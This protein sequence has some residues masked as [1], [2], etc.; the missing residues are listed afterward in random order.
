[1]ALGEYDWREK[2]NYP[3]ERDSTLCASAGILDEDLGRRELVFLRMGAVVGVGRMVLSER[4]YAD[5][6]SWFAIGWSRYVKTTWPALGVT[7]VENRIQHYDAK[8]HEVEVTGSTV[9]IGR[10]FAGF[11]AQED[12]SAVAKLGVDEF[13]RTLKSASSFLEGCTITV[14]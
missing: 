7:I 9:P 11:C 4:Q 6:I 8:L 10:S 14:E 5:A 13:G 12:S 2:D 1:M 3:K